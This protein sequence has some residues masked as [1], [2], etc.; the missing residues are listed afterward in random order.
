MSKLSEAVSSAGLLTNAGTPQYNAVEWLIETD[1]FLV[2]P[3]DQNMIQRYVMAIFYFS[4]KGDS[5]DICS[6]DDTVCAN[7]YLSSAHECHWFGN[8]C[9]AAMYIIEIEQGKID[10]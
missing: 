9:D 8:Q 3:D 7:P 6:Q 2:C 1:G 4:T 10:K 5:W